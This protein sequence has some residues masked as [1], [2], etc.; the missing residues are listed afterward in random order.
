M[1]YLL[2]SMGS[3]WGVASVSTVTQT[4][5]SSKLTE[6]FSGKPGGAEVSN[7]LLLKFVSPG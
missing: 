6:A 7:S 1:V 4:V 2:R 3:V 5:L